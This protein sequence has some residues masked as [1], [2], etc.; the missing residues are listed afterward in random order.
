MGRRWTRRHHDCGRTE[1]RKRPGPYAPTRENVGHERRNE[2]FKPGEHV[3]P[4]AN[5]RAAEKL[6]TGRRGSR[7]IEMGK[8]WK[9][10][11]ALIHTNPFA[12]KAESDSCHLAN[13]PRP[14]REGLLD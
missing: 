9:S 11:P 3:P 5:S 2:R 7:R 6:G 8:E 1:Q 14:G 13:S 12:N 10:D 4:S